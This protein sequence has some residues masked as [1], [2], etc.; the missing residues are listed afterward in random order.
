[1]SEKASDESFSAHSVTSRN[2][3]FQES[4]V[5]AL[6]DLSDRDKVW[7]KHK[8]NSDIVSQHYSRS[9]YGRYAERINI[10]ADLLEFKL[11]PDSYQG[12]YKLKLSAARFC[13]VRTCPVCQWRRSLMW[14]AKAHKV[15][16][17]VVE[18]YPKHR[19]VFLTLTVKNCPITE[20]KSTLGWMHES[21]KRLTKLKI[22]TVEG[23]IKSTEVTRGKDGSAHPHFHCL[24]M[25]PP[26]YFKGSK[27]ISQEKWTELWQQCLRI[28]YK[29]MVHVRAIAKRHDPQV[30]IPEIL[31]YQ[32]KESDLVKDREWF[33]ELTKQLHKTRAV[34][35]GG[36]L[37]TY[38]KE[39]E[40]EPEDLIGESDEPDQVDE[41]S[42]YF[43]WKKV[44][45][46]YRM[47][48]P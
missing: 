29:P 45:K 46:K 25:V 38:L 18:A 36:V 40:Q 19:W 2:D 5:P 16:P 35:V 27:Y 34:A 39:L 24:L 3:S 26:S 48:D 23:W 43:R 28:D 33:I 9:S 20:L 13:R 6:S 4:G 17:K 10:C 12:A 37:K 44:E 1:M 30:I 32:V 15:L 42:L 41:G 7:D 14:K 11:S 31:K 22:W 47:V 8:A 21:F